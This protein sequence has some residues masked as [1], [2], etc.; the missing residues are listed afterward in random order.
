MDDYLVPS[1]SLTPDEAKDIVQGRVPIPNI[2]PHGTPVRISLELARNNYLRE[3]ENRY[4]RFMKWI[5]TGAAVFILTGLGYIGYK[6]DQVGKKFEQ[7][8]GLEQRVDELS[9]SFTPLKEAVKNFEDSSTKRLGDISEIL[10]MI[11]YQT[12]EG[13]KKTS[14]ELKNALEDLRDIRA[15]RAELLKNVEND[16]RGIRKD[17]ESVTGPNSVK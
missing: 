5:M 17:L 13:L 7:M 6:L 4:L 1:G 10:K 3:A 15:E 16:L 14:E 11:Q 9:A 8:Y 2:Y 12:S